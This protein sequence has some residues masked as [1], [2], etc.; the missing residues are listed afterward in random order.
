MYEYKEVE[1]ESGEKKLLRRS[2]EIREMS[3][4]EAFLFK[5]EVCYYKNPA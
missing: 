2:K 1:D 4:R 5:E 3:T